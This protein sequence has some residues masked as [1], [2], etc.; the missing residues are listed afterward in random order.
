MAKKIIKTESSIP[1]FEFIIADTPSYE[2]LYETEYRI[3]VLIGTR[4]VCD[5]IFNTNKNKFVLDPTVSRYGPTGEVD[6][7]ILSRLTKY[8]TEF[9]EYY[10]PL[11]LDTRQK[12]DEYNS[13]PV[14][15]IS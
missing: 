12:V 11:I 5:I 6:F 10:H 9:I 13:H 15:T 14:S 1:E 8:L 3:D 7:D 2:M 4:I